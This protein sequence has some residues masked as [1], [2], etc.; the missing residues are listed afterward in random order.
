MQD[1][2]RSLIQINIAVL[3][4]GV[5]GLFGKFLTTPAIGLVFGRTLFGALALALILAW[6]KESPALKNKKE[7]IYFF[8]LGAILAVHWST[9]FYSIQISTV[10]IGLLTYSTFP[11]FVTFLEP[12]LLR[13]AL[14]KRDVLVALVVCGGLVLIVPEYDLKNNITL[15][16]LWGTL[17]GLLFALLSVLN[18]KYVQKHSAITIAFYQ[19]GFACLCTLPFAFMMNPSVL[20]HDFFYLLLLGIFCTALSH[21]LFIQ[22]MIRIK[23]QLASV[24]AALEPVYGIVL[25]IL[26]LGE[27]PGLRTV[28]GGLII[29]GAVIYASMKIPR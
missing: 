13:E 9:F 15:G 20:L 16:V 1:K 26:F 21:T 29:L 22:S 10:A 2:T 28:I 6:K 5:A 4:F 27:L 17:S 7:Y 19:N 3:L 14:K 8:L 18:R 24:I 12:A 25:A 11:V 23:A